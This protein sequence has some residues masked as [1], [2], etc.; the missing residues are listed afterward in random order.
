MIAVAFFMLKV[1]RLA[2]V[3]V[4]TNNSALCLSTDNH[5]AIPLNW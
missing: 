5:C 4:V 3:G 1:S 2:V